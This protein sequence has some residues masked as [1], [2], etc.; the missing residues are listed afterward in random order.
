MHVEAHALELLENTGVKP[1]QV[2][3]DFGCGCGTYAIPAAR[4]V[5]DRGEV[6]ALDKD[7]KAL[8]ELMQKAESTG[9]NNLE[10]VDTH[11]E[12]GIDLADNSVA[13]V[14][15]LEVPTQLLQRNAVLLQL[16]PPSV[17]SFHHHHKPLSLGRSKMRDHLVT[18]L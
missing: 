13:A 16:L 4:I 1:G 15:G 14:V 7:S 8:D 11:G 10:R 6:Y 12:L 2:V 5:G 18:D 3:L 17:P 9:L